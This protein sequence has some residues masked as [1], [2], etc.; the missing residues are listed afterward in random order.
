[1]KTK[2]FNSPATI[3]KSFNF[4]IP[5]IVVIF[6]LL[7][8]TV[9]LKSFFSEDSNTNTTKLIEKEATEAFGTDVVVPVFEDYPITFAAI[10]KPD[11][12]DEPSDLKIIY[13]NENGE[14]NTKSNNKEE[15]R[16]WELT[17]ESKLLYGSLNAKALFDIEYRKGK[18]T[19]GDSDG[20]SKTINGIDV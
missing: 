4:I 13:S 17:N 2:D 1:M 16:A 11:F 20:K 12:L 7:L 19:L 9:L 14:I 5:G 10:T 3:R 18:V 8:D 15:I 6:V